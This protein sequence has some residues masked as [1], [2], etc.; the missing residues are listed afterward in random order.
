MLRYTSVL[1]FAYFSLEIFTDLPFLFDVWSV[2]MLNVDLVNFF[3]KIVSKVSNGNTIQ[4]EY[5]LQE[6][7]NVKMTNRAKF[8]EGQLA[9]IWG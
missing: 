5:L 6:K 2:T 7:Y 3:S 1:C 9:Q 8:F 4:P